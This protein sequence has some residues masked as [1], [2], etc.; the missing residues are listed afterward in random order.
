MIVVVVSAASTWCASVSAEPLKSASPEYV[1][2]NVFAPADVDVSEHVPAPTAAE[3]VLPSP[4]STVTV[5][6][7]VPTPGRFTVV[8]HDT[9]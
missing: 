6:V 7:G 3:Q 1:A 5:P 8:V 2:V 9:S 4:S